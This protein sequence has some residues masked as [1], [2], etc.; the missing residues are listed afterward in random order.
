MDLH[1][2]KVQLCLTEW[3]HGSDPVRLRSFS[4]TLDALETTYRRRI[5]SAAITLIEASTNSYAVARRLQA[6]GFEAK[7][8]VSEIASGLSAPDRVNDAID[9]YN[10]VL[11]YVRRANGHKSACARRANGHKS[12]F[13]HSRCAC[14]H[15][16]TCGCL[17][18]RHRHDRP[19]DHLR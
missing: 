12:A 7:V 8:L 11:A 16:G 2:R 19:G 3:I 10:I 14:A 4:T 18:R 13:R 1:S 15:G 17:L 5:P 9:A 6:I